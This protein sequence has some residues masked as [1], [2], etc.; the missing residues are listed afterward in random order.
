MSALQELFVTLK[1]NTDDFVSKMNDADKKLGTWQKS[2][3][4][5]GQNLEKMGQK[6]MLAGTAIVGSLFLMTDSWASAGDQISQMQ[7][8]TGM[9]AESLSELKYVMDQVGGTF[10]NLAAPVKAMNIAIAGAADQAAAM[11]GKMDLAAAAADWAKTPFGQ[12]GFSLESLKAMN[13]DQQFSALVTALQ[14]VG[15]ESTKAALASQIFG[16]GSTDLMPLIET[17]KTKVDELK[18]T[19]H[20]LNVVFTDD[21]AAAAGAFEES[22]KKLTTS[23]DGLKTSI[24]Q[25]LMPQLTDLLGKMTNIVT[26]VGEWA[27]A[28]PA[29]T[30]ALLDFG[31]A[32][33]VGGTIIMGL[34]M[35]AKA[36]QSV[37]VALAILQGLSNPAKL[38]LG[39]G[40][41]A[42][43]VWGITE[44][45]KD[46]NSTSSGTDKDSQIKQ[47]DQDYVS[48][49]LTLSQWQSQMDKLGSPTV[50]SYDFGGIV[51]GP[52]GAPVPVIAHGGEEFLGKSGSAS[53]ASIVINNPT[54]MDESSMRDFA[55]RVNAYTQQDGRRNSFIQLNGGSLFR[56]AV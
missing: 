12:L 25:S 38:A 2:V 29:L 50:P 56:N 23:F 18:S 21:S 22:K 1:A 52:I 45:M 24:A 49:R 55:R 26:K 33:A 4:K 27:T 3:D 47:L 32:L 19:A 31:L 44:L 39:L 17:E 30:K 7:A 51:P 14:G 10:T 5:A 15:D 43:G 46:I 9:S 34:G 16:K 35:L 8:K 13:P 37:S 40:A 20:D 41:A 53:G 36:I 28:H 11:A 48:G 42:L 54:F 6:L